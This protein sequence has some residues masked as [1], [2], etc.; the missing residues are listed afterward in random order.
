[1]RAPASVSRFGAGTC[2][3]GAGVTTGTAKI[4]SLVERAMAILKSW[5]VL[6]KLRCTT[7]RITAVVR[8]VA[9]LELAI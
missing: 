6:R 5:R 1:M 3:A 8:A 9:T 4:R 2:A 7:T